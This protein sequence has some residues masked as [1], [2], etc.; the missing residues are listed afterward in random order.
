M[1]WST[2]ELAE[3]AG[4][5]VRAVRHHHVIGLLDAPQRN[6]NGY[7]QYGVAHLVRTLRIKRLTDLGF[8]LPQIADMGATDRHPRVALR[9]L[10]AELARSVER[11]RRMR[12]EV[13]QILD[14]AAPID[15]PLELGAAI[16]DLDLSDADRSLLVVMSRVL[17]PAAVNALVETLR[18]LPTSPAAS[19][20]DDLPADADES[21]CRDLARRL[22]P[23]TPGLRSRLPGLLDADPSSGS[24][25]SAARTI[26]MAVSDL[27]NLAQIDVLCRVRHR[28]ASLP[29]ATPASAPDRPATV[30]LNDRDGRSATQRCSAPLKSIRPVRITPVS[31]LLRRS[32]AAW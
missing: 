11:L 23:L 28:R 26:N 8:S 2:R 1:A 22:L 25:A 14:Q 3:L 29:H 31:A 16:C 17:E 19:A 18:T 13:E 5:T 32:A 7:K 10:D 30:D 9:R 24:A 6:A 21:T 4:T 12:V 20:F 15:L 27:Y